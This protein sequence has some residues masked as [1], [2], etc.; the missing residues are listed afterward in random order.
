MEEEKEESDWGK[1]FWVFA[2]GVHSALT[3]SLSLH[4]QLPV[5][6]VF[7]F[8]FLVAFHFFFYFFFIIIHIFCC[9]LILF[10]ESTSRACLIYCLIAIGNLTGSF[11]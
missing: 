7:V 8:Y 1:A 5:P 3:L 9:P 10:L 4:K 6:F 11:H 2:F